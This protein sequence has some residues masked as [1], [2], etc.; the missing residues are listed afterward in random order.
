MKIH[1]LTSCAILVGLLG[2][3]TALAADTVPLESKQNAIATSS[4]AQD[5]LLF[6]EEQD[7]V[8]ATKRHTTVR[9]APAVATIID[10]DEI[11]N[12]GARNLLDVLK[13]VPG[14]GISIN[15]IG[16]N[17]IEVR[18]I[19]TVLSEKIL[20]MIDGH[21]LNRNINGSALYNVAEM[22]PLA[23]VRQIEVVRGP[24]SALYGNSAFVAT[25]NVITRNAEEIN[26]LELKAG[27]GSFG[28]WKGNM[29]GGT[30][31]RDMLT[32]SWSLDHHQSDGQNLNIEADALTGTTNQS[33]APGSPYVAFK[34]TDAFLKVNYG[35]LSFRSH[36]IKR[37]KD[38]YIGVTYALTDEPSVDHV[39]N[40]WGELAYNRTIV[41]GLAVKAKLS[42]DH[43]EQDPFVKIY[44]NGFAGVYVNGMIAKPLVKNDTVNTELQLDW[45]VFPGNHLI[46]G[47]SFE[48]LHQY[49][50]KQLANFNPAPLPNLQE[51][52]NWNKDA[53]RNIIALYLQDE[54]QLPSQVNF[55][56]GVRYDHYSDFGDTVNPRIGMVWSFHDNADLKLLYGQA[57]RAPNFQ[58]LYNINNP[59]VVGNPDL[60]P[61]KIKTYEAGVSYR[62]NRYLGTSANYFYSTITDQ[63]GWVPSATTGQ[64]TVNANIGKSKTQGVELGFNGT[65]TRE[66]SW[67]TNY[68]YQDP[69]DDKTDKRL[70]YV[71]MHRAS[72]SLNYAPV[73]Y[74][75]LHTDV[76]WTGTRSRTDADT[77][78]KMPSYTTVDLAVTL[79][80][81]FET[82]EIQ[83]AVHNI[84][85]K[86]YSDPDTSGAAKL[87]P[88][89]FPREGLSTLVTAS[90]KF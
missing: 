54:W 86:H 79:K 4:T 23:N 63:I 66:F 9:K 34:Q 59:Y 29:V 67:K 73:K 33:L 58:E 26:G 20:F 64:A 32:I 45:D 3:G 22:L 7:L 11:R 35:D 40:Y 10:A 24:V 70:L 36:Y 80:R 72:A 39:E 31:L 6:M 8:T 46:V 85:D 15:E 71:P 90:Y 17:M 18:G 61:E 27:G 43:Y 48:N 78:S 76:L 38:A 77:R 68:T 81:F 57:F 84:F 74:L 2:S 53:N 49:D 55:T 69:R 28:T 42:Y 51:I 44:S 65:I 19:R 82:L 47:T 37:Q 14:L 5:L 62:L 13:M 16:A 25:V 87:V 50:V 30:T 89:D 21:S 1:L 12:M 56:A 41:S 60:K 88:G 52:A 83:A 75:N